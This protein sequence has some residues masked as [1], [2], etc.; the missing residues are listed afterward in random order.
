[1]NKLTLKFFNS[2]LELQYQNEKIGR[3]RKPV[4]YV[5]MTLGLILNVSKVLIDLGKLQLSY[6]YINYI[7]IAL[8]VVLILISVKWPLYIRYTLMIA[9]ISSSLL[10]LNFPENT[11]SQMYY[12]YGSN[13]MEF[14]ACAYFVSDF[15]DSVVQVICHTII[16]LIITIQTTQHVDPQDVLM[17]I[18]AAVMIVIVIYICDANARKEFLSKICE[19]VLDRQLS[20]LI[21]LP[22]FQV[23]YCQRLLQFNFLNGKDLL[24]FPNYDEELCDGCNVRN[25][26]RQY[27]I[28]GQ[29]LQEFLIKNQEG[30]VKIA[31][32]KHKFN[33]R[34]VNLGID[35]INK[36]VILDSQQSKNISLNQSIKKP[37]KIYIQQTSQKNN[38]LFFNWGII[39]LLLV[40]DNKIQELSLFKILSR[41]NNK[42]SKYSKIK[43]HLKGDETLSISSYSNLIRI[44]LIQIYQIITHFYE[45]Q[46]IKNN[47]SQTKPKT[48]LITMIIY[49][50]CD[51]IILQLPLTINP[52]FFISKY[53]NNFF[54]R[55]IEQKILNSPLTSD[56]KIY[57]NTSLPFK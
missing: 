32:S 55:Q 40:N 12:S 38:Q 8:A 36:I 17:G 30:S 47:K 3:L 53:S 28:E 20:E 49:K 14:Q 4:F 21:K 33:L 10:Q 7:L 41:F 24:E 51:S 25:L 37:I 56:L 54:I 52:M 19:N 48:F 57:F 29:E 31:I 35:H 5:F 43:F 23:T 50:E 22:F 46:E 34:V 42:F 39:S 44:Y 1:M 27:K 15:L 11:K 13:F 2:Q 45:S 9:N 16:K 18:G 6:Q 26:L